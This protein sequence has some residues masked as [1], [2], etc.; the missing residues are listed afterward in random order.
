M[1]NT[2][3]NKNNVSLVNLNIISSI[4]FII[5][6]LVSLSITVDEKNRLLN[7]KRYYTNKEALNISFYNRIVILIA[8]LI[9]LYVGYTNYKN[10]END[11][12]A[13]YKSSILLTTNILTVIGALLIL[14]VSY[15]NKQEQT[16]NTSDVENPL[17]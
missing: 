3:S 7:K 17:I 5:A 14:Y 1:N 4:T 10:E 12:V 9:S 11:T 2:S 13:K 16:L 8:V 15:L 6:S